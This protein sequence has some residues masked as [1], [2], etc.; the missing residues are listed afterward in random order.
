MIDDQTNLDRLRA[1]RKWEIWAQTAE[2]FKAAGAKAKAYPGKCNSWPGWPSAGSRISKTYPQARRRKMATKTPPRWVSVLLL[3]LVMGFGQLGETRIKAAEPQMVEVF[4]NGV[5]GYPVYRIPSLICTPHGS[6]LAFCEA[7]S[8]GDQSPTDMVLRRSLDRG[9]TWLP[10][11]VIVKAVPE[12][13]MDPTPV[14]D[15]ATGAVLLVYDRWPIMPKGREL[16]T[17]TRAP[18][19]GRDSVTTWITTS[20]DDG[21]TWSTPVDITAMTKK[22]QW[23]ESVHGPGVG[24]QTRSGRLVIPCSENRP[25]AAKW[26]VW[27]NFAVYSDDHGRTWQLSDNEVGPGVNESQVVELTDGTLL[28][29]MRSD[30]GGKGCRIGATSNDGGKTWSKPFDVCAL[31]DTCCQGSILRYTWAD[32]K[33]G[34]SR[35]LFCNPVKSGRS[36]G[37]VRLSYDEG[38]TWP[39]SKMICRDYFGYSCLTAMPDGAIGCLFETAG[40]GKIAFQCFSLEWLTDG[41]D[42]WKP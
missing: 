27:W 14:V 31:P 26:G 6:L 5:G 39:V 36:E 16:G 23:T 29:N 17:F 20:N 4:A 3:I 33:G 24:I 11:Q 21:A 32:Q 42:S 7:R 40:C 35:I 30:D 28:L 38:K 8:G 1:Y 18:G 2:R 19:L 25:S 12:A 22:P 41:N 9:K 10:M 15:R 37:T 13:V 34:K